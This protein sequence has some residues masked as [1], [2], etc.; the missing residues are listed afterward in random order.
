MTP[1][2]GFKRHSFCIINVIR[3][4]VYPNNIVLYTKPTFPYLQIHKCHNAMK[5]NRL[6]RPVMTLY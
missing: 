4:R 3:D 5:C 1:P 6:C 2:F